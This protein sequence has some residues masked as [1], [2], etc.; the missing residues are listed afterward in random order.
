MLITCHRPGGFDLGLFDLRHGE[1]II[2]DELW[3]LA[4]TRIDP[5][6]LDA[7][8]SGPRPEIEVHGSAAGASGADSEVSTDDAPGPEQAPT[9]ARDKNAA[10]DASY[11]GDELDAL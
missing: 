7:W 9:L 4:V 8:T 10:V 5:R 3:L 1:N 11:S 6:L 2:E